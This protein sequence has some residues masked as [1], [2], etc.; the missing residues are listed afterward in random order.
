MR[1]SCPIFLLLPLCLVSE[2][3]FAATNTGTRIALHRKATTSNPASICTSYSPNE[4]LLLCSQYT[5]TGPAPGASLVY[6]VAALADPEAGVREVSIG[7]DYDGRDQSSGNPGEPHGIAPLF[8]QFNSCANGL[9]YSDDGGFGDWP[10]PKSGLHITWMECR[11]D[12]IGGT[13]HAVVGAL[14]VYAYSEDVLRITPNNVRYDDRSELRV[15]DC[16]GG[17]TDLLPLYPPQL[18]ESLTG[19]VHL[20]GDGSQGFNPCAAVPVNS[21]SWGR[22]KA[23][24]SNQGQPLPGL[25]RP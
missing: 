24:Y 23:R 6:V 10:K 3:A 15:V 22:M 8:T 18:W 5:V 2:P 14:Y 16:L 19:R 13:T 4:D 21:S 17:N 12:M 1:A 7:I 11:T 9:L 20:G 25:E